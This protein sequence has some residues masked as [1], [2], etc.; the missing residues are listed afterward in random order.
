MFSSFPSLA[1]VLLPDIHSERH[2][3]SQSPQKK[4]IF[5]ASEPWTAAPYGNLHKA[6]APASAD[7]GSVRSSDVSGTLPLD[8]QPSRARLSQCELDQK[9]E[10]AISQWTNDPDTQTIAARGGRRIS[11]TL[12]I[13][14][15][16]FNDK[17]FVRNKQIYFSPIRGHS[18]GSLCSSGPQGFRRLTK[19]VLLLLCCP[20]TMLFTYRRT[21]GSVRLMNEIARLSVTEPLHRK[22]WFPPTTTVSDRSQSWSIYALFQLQGSKHTFVL[23]IL[24]VN[25]KFY[26]VG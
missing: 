11:Q 7:L 18:A 3:G 20:P 23:Y 10:L 4:L 21:S 1:S 5:L 12:F 15:I 16:F 8:Y 2:P 9:H 24:K 25:V 26:K 19:H 13:Y 17:M 14:L 22:S 6:D